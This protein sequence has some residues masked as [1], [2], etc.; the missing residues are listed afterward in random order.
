MLTLSPWLTLELFPILP[1]AGLFTWVFRRMSRPLYRVVRQ[2]VSRLNENLQENLS[3]IEIVQLYGRERENFA[4]YSA[5]NRDNMTSLSR[6]FAIESFY[7]PLI[8][9]LNFI[10]LCIIVWGGGRL[11]L[12]SQITIGSLLLFT[13]FLDMLFQPIVALGEQWNVVFRAMASGERILQA[14]DWKDALHE[15][16]S[17]IPLPGKL[18]GRVEFRHLT[19]G[20]SKDYPILRDV[21]FTIDPGERIAIVGPTGSGKTSL[22][23]LLCRFYDVAPGQIYLDG[24]DIMNVRPA[25][26]RTRIGVVLQ[27]FHIFS[28]SVYDNISLGNPDISRDAAQKAARLVYADNFIRQLPQGYDTPLNER[29]RNLSHG[30]RQLL[31]FA[32]VLAMNPEVLVLDEATASIDTETELVIQD[33]LRKLTAGRTSIIIAHRLQTIKDAHRVIVLSEGSVREMGTHAELLARGGIYRTLYELQYQKI[34]A[35]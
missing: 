31:A 14:L 7:G 4:R 24:I 25:D 10:G 15:P 13:Q 19:F 9:S 28:G 21:S 18:S 1:V 11:V 32:R 8:N 26:I 23:R 5:I 6:A 35:S 17:P 12:H 34:G 30:Q 16:E 33:A 3:G 29:G 22:I 27:D 20:Y 2:S